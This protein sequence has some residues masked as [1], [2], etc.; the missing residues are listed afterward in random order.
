MALSDLNLTNARTDDF[1]YRIGNDRPYP[2]SDKVTSNL[3]QPSLLDS[4]EYVI[5]T[6][7]E[8][9]ASKPQQISSGPT[10]ATS[11]DKPLVYPLI[12]VEAQKMFLRMKLFSDR[13]AN[14]LPDT[15]IYLPLP[16]GALREETGVSWGYSDLGISGQYAKA[17]VEWI[18][19][20]FSQYKGMMSTMES[21]FG[22]V[23]RGLNTLLERSIV[24]TDL[25]DALKQGA[26]VQVKPEFTFMFE[27]INKLRDFR[28]EW[29]FV[30]K[31]ARDAKA[32]EV[33]IKE[34]Q[35]AS[36]PTVSD[37]SMFDEVQKFITLDPNLTPQIQQG[38]VVHGQD[39]DHKLYSST[40]IIPKEIE[41]SVFERTGSLYEGINDD[42]EHIA[43]FPIPFVISD[44]SIQS[45][46]EAAE[47]DVFLYDEVSDE[48]YY[49]SYYIL[50]GFT[51]LT[52]YTA[53]NVK[54]YRTFNP[55]SARP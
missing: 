41:M 5:E 2:S 47:A 40:F 17:G 22:Q 1:L 37:I 7:N 23:G 34:I 27:G 29:K 43:D 38:D 31:N 30:P 21:V 33:I 54:D 28:L 46:G 39:F 36:L 50:I 20:E 3:V 10:K 13:K 19:S 24:N 26:G 4:S 16:L 48:Y 55:T 6:R 15:T 25:F 45:G 51:E 53:E 49:S 32:I 14:R 42:L 12:P 35:K 8:K 44:I 18:N 9:P 52:H 11:T